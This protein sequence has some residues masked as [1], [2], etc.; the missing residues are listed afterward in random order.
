MGLMPL[1]AGADV[2][3][4]P[5]TSRTKNFYVSNRV[6]LEPSQFIPLPLG[7]VRPKGWL[8]VVLQRQRDELCGHLT[9]ARPNGCNMI[10]N[11]R[12]LF[13][14]SKYIGST[15]TA[16]ASAEFPK[17][18]GCLTGTEM[19]GKPCQKAR[20]FQPKQTSSIQLHFLP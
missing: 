20:P 4:V 2:V 14:Q 13:R 8:L 6:P 7:S 16:P 11:N 1:Q 12:S 18:G 15:A 17:S 10:S 19:R 9:G 5:D 3:T